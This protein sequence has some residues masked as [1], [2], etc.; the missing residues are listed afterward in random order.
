MLQLLKH[1]EKVMVCDGR[2]ESTGHSTKYCTYVDV[3]AN[4]GKEVDAVVFPL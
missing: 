4:T 3:E 1:Q 2:C